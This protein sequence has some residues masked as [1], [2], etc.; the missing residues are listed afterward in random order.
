[1]RERERLGRC[2]TLFSLGGHL[3]RAMRG[4]ERGE[5]GQAVCRVGVTGR[6]WRRYG[7]GEERRSFFFYSAG[8]LPAHPAPTR[9][10]FAAPT[11]AA[12]PSLFSPLFSLAHTPPP[13]PTPLSTQPCPT[14]R[15]RSR[16]WSGATSCRPTHT[17]ARAATSSKSPRCEQ[18]VGAA[19]RARAR[20]CCAT[21]TH[22]GATEGVHA[23]GGV[24]GAGGSGSGCDPDACVRRRHTVGTRAT[25]CSLF[26]RFPLGFLGRRV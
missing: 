22:A 17:R 19:C 18:G 7:G 21:S 24:R 13:S 8:V 16:T 5:T 9:A 23:A 1:M 26:M 25:G 14:R 2:V 11:P 12:L 20:L 6:G 4:Q 10:F 15:L 3:V